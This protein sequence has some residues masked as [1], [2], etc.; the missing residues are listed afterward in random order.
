MTVFVQQYNV[1]K[2]KIG[3]EKSTSNDYDLKLSPPLFTS[4]HPRKR[5]S[6]GLKEIMGPLQFI[7]WRT[8]EL[9]GLQ[10]SE[11][12]ASRNCAV[13]WASVVAAPLKDPCKWLRDLVSVET[14]GT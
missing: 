5:L 11:G 14:S 8:G 13:A 12:S 4:S 6:L 1:A 10:G 2:I 7:C 9:L 3:Q